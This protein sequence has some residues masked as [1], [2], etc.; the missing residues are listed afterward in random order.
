VIVTVIAL[1]YTMMGGITAVIWTDVI[2]AGVF[3]VLTIAFLYW[4]NAW[5]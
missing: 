3:F 1:I 4:F 5:I 2:Q